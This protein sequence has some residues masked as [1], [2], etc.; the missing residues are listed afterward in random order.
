MELCDL[1]DDV[2]S[3]IFSL[4]PG[5]SLCNFAV[6]C[7]WASSLFSRI[8]QSFWHNL[9][10]LILALTPALP[11]PFLLNF[12]YNYVFHI[13]MCKFL[14]PL[15]L[16]PVSILKNVFFDFREPSSSF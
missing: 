6:S 15:L 3:L 9:V 11:P 5:R 1:P 16:E 10:R 13:N 8:P 7:H 14:L 4:V 12:I 2:F